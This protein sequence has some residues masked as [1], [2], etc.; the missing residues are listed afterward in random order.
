M[1]KD[2]DLRRCKYVS[3]VS[4]LSQFT[5]G[6]C[7][8]GAR[9]PLSIPL[10]SPS[11]LHSA[12]LLLARGPAQGEAGGGRK[13]FANDNN[14]IRQSTC[15]WLQHMCAC[16]LQNKHSSCITMVIIYYSILY[17]LNKCNKNKTHFFITFIT[18]HLTDAFEQSFCTAFF[19]YI[20]TKDLGFSG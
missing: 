3:W 13:G 18:M 8:K 16:V 4:I 19:K 12:A 15:R 7:P 20:L 6:S 2:G 17:N 11:E 10:P 1:K 5:V 14:R 9:Q